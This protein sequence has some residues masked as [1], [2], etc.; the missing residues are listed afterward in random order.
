MTE[1]QGCKSLQ[2]LLDLTEVH[3]KMEREIL[4]APDSTTLSPALQGEMRLL[5]KTMLRQIENNIDLGDQESTL[6]V[7]RLNRA[8]TQTEHSDLPQWQNV[9]IGHDGIQDSI[10][11]NRKIREA[12]LGGSRFSEE[13]KQT[14]DMVSG[15]IVVDKQILGPA[16][17]QEYVKYL[18]EESCK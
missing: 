6:I 5:A 16:E 17:A 8:V 14:L 3:R 18:L 15:N 4:A 7:N 10:H 1:Y 9:L 11:L 2:I 13:T 12:F